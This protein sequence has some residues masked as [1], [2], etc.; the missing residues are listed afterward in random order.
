MVGVDCHKTHMVEH[1]LCVAVFKSQAERGLGQKA[2][3]YE[4]QQLNEDH[5]SVPRTRVDP[6][7]AIL[8]S[9]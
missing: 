8:F 2:A 1:V 4:S 9:V 5:R 7:R 6:S 3:A